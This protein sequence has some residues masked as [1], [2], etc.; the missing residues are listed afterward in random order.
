MWRSKQDRSARSSFSPAFLSTSVI[1][2]PNAEEISETV[3]IR[4]IAANE[5][6]RLDFVIEKPIS[7]KCHRLTIGPG[8][9]ATGD[10]IAQEVIVYGQ[11]VGS[12]RGADRIEIKGSGSIIGDLTTRRFVVE[13]GGFFKGTVQIERRKTPRGVP[14]LV[15]QGAM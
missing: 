14:E 1:E 5:D 15:A 2:P 12:L 13:N 3:V 7:M 8:A 9:K 11:L 6:V 4:K 10:V